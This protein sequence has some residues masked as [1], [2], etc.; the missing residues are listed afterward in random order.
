LTFFTSAMSSGSAFSQSITR[1]KSAIWK[2]GSSAFL[3][4]AT[5]VLAALH[6]R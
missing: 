3:L 1:P 2:I 6:A 5:M 4:M